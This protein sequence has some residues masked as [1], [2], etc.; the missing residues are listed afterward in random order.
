MF[1][2]STGMIARILFH[3]LIKVTLFTIALLQWI[4][5]LANNRQNSHEYDSLA[6]KVWKRALSKNIWRSEIMIYI[7]GTIYL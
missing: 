1:T 4:I 3:G 7:Y 2:L 6:R 5:N